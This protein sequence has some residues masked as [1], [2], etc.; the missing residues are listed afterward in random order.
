MPHLYSVSFGR[1]R[2]CAFLFLFFGSGGSGFAP[3]IPLA[4]FLFL[5]LHQPA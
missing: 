5:D 1:F 2:A 3:M 4:R